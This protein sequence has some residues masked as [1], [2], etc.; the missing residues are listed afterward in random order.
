MLPAFPVVL[1][2]IIAYYY[3]RTMWLLCHCL[4]HNPACN[5]SDK[6]SIYYFE[7]FF[8][9]H[10]HWCGLK[11]LT[12]L[13]ILYIE[14]LFSSN[15]TADHVN[16]LLYAKI[17]PESS[18]NQVTQLLSKTFKDWGRNILSCLCKQDVFNTKKSHRI[19]M[20]TKKLHK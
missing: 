8:A 14:V 1:R 3:L 4:L 10:P 15:S 6:N 13:K 12:K 11:Y 20:D 2:N 16:S 19:K 7:M 17:L 18:S 9:M 5:K